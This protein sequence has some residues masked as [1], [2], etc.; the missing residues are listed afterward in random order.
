MIMNGTSDRDTTHS[1]D[2]TGI[3][4]HPQRPLPPNTQ[5]LRD[6]FIC[7]RGYH[8]G[9]SACPENS[10]SAFERAVRRGLAIECDVQLLADDGIAVFHDS[11]TKRMTGVDRLIAVCDAGQVRSMR[12]LDSNQTVP[13]LEDMLD[14]V[15]GEVPLLIEMKGFGD[16]GRFCRALLRKLKGYD[17]PFALQSFNPKA[18]LWLR[19][20]A[21]Q[22]PRGQISGSLQD[23]KL[24]WHRKVLVKNLLT[25]GTTRPHFISYEVEC[26]PHMK[27]VQ[28]L[29]E[30][31][32]VI[33]W[34]VSSLEQYKRLKQHCDNVI[35]EGFDPFAAF[36]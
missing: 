4:T 13:L 9:S 3:E 29:R 34:T 30:Q 26:I 7:H 12:L 10:L 32:P 27:R 6:I 33:G 8:G 16:M 23:V 28:K 25:N 1:P 20:H 31:M 11:N 19:L 24:P 2:E 15:G 5:W 17:G 14:V 22:I 36:V 21:P 35:F 18:L